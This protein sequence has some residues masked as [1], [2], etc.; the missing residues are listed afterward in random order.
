MLT[1][2]LG[3]KKNLQSDFETTLARVPQALAAEGFGVLTTIDVADTLK[4]KLGAEFRRYRILGA[5]NPALAHRALKANLD[6]GVMLPCN[7]VVYEADEGGT[8]VVAMDPLQAPAAR[9]DPLIRGVAEEVR[10][11]L[12][13][14]LEHLENGGAGS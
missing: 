12:E 4:R 13:R 11:K 9:A 10:V 2:A 5:C 1:M 7:V 14:A 8:V 6:V 3:L